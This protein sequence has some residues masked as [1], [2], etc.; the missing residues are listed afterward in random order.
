M[1][2]LE[3]HAQVAEYLVAEY[4]HPADSQKRFTRDIPAFG[5]PYRV[6]REAPDHGV[7]ARGI[8]VLVGNDPRE[9]RQLELGPSLQ[10][11][12]KRLRLA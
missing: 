9:T 1:I 4:L 2:G 5:G 3:N 11:R 7:G 8:G 10:D 6:L 12:T